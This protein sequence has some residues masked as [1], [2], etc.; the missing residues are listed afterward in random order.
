MKTEN[1]T[2]KEVTDKVGYALE[3]FIKKYDGYDIDEY[4]FNEIFVGYLSDYIKTTFYDDDLDFGSDYDYSALTNISN[5]I[6]NDKNCKNVEDVGNE[7]DAGTS[8]GCC[9]PMIE[10]VIEI[11]KNR[12]KINETH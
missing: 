7:I 9:I 3:D 2:K 11:E 10:R 8:C 12:R 4:E 1:L 6:I 5:D